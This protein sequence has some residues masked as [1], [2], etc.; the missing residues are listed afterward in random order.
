MRSSSLRM[1]LQ[2]SLCICMI[3]IPESS[4]HKLISCFWTVSTALYNVAC[5]GLKVPFAGNVRAKPSPV[6]QYTIESV[7]SRTHLYRTRNHC[8]SHC[9]YMPLAKKYDRL[10]VFATRVYEDHFAVGN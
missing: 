10:L 9:E 2:D 3:D 5:S 1:R 7:R 4:V 8:G 6:V